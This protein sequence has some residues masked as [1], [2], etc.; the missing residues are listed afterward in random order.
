M[1]Q[2]TIRVAV[3][4]RILLLG[5]CTIFVQAMAMAM[6][7]DDAPINVTIDYLQ[8]LYTAVD[9]DHQLHTELYACNTCHHHT[10]GD[11]PNNQKCGKCHADSGA[12]DDVSCS[13]CHAASQGIATPLDQSTAHALYHIDK[14]AIKGALHLQCLGC[15][16]A[17]D[18]PTG[19]LDCH[20]FTVEGQKRFV[21]DSSD[22]D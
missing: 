6:D 17:E 15:H 14:P 12:S 22:E 5:L 18:G 10:T 13:G 16:Q 19:C 3:W 9:F 8:Q 21:V 11:G 4:G 20:A 1:T 7:G 2:T